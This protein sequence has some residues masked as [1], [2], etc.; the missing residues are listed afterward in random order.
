MIIRTALSFSDSVQYFI[1]FVSME[2]YIVVTF[3]I[4]E[5]VLNSSS[6]RLSPPPLYKGVVS[7][8]PTIGTYTWCLKNLINDYNFHTQN[9]F[10]NEYLIKT[11]TSIAPTS[12]Q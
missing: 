9:V 4:K 8:V 10:H 1:V 2:V 7:T 12:R 3:N 5:Y 6:C 11:Y